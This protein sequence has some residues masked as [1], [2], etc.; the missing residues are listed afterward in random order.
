M[1]LSGSRALESPPVDEAM[2]DIAH[3]L[4]VAALLEP[5]G[6]GRYRGRT[7]PRYANMVGPFGGVIAAQLLNAVLLHPDRFGEPIA[8]TVNYAG[9][10]A[11]GEFEVA[12]RT[13]RTNR[14][15][16]HWLVELS[17]GEQLC[18]TASGV[19]AARRETWSQV[20]AAFPQVP[21]A[22]ALRRFP[23]LG[24]AAWTERYD[25]RFVKGELNFTSPAHPE[26]DSV[27]VLW[28]RDDPP[29]PLDF[30]SLIAISDSFFPRIFV[31]RP[32]WAPIGTIS[33]TTYFHA[34]AAML[35]ANGDAAVL[36][37]ARAHQ[38]RNGYFDQAAEVWGEAG[39][40][41][42]TSHQIVYYRE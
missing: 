31:R 3:P 37:T 17:Q 13:A 36:G 21:P 19:F 7:S 34:D 16:Q 26:Q 39:T 23:M 27:S 32:V 30:V 41:L 11:D 33:F 15:T 9:P 22:S 6:E 24:R 8:F 14:S 29:R 1:H 38:F 2:A 25:M 5:L 20:E 18:A 40:L 35:A 10:I 42:A 12:A 4:D 28:I